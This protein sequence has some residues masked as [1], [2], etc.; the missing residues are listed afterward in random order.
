ML[1]LFYDCIDLS[2]ADSDG[3]LVHEWLKKA[4]AR[5]RKPISQNSITW[6]LHLSA[7]EEYVE[8]SA[9][10]VWLA[11]QHAV[12]SVLNHARF[13]KIFGRILDLSTEERKCASQRHVDALGV[14]LALRVTGRVLL[15]MVVNAGSFL[16]MRGFDW[17]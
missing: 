7:N 13:S 17:V 6:L 16:R 2:D 10:N 15:P 3:W 5:E 12:R 1:R 9:R 8:F 4:Y 14:W 11:Q